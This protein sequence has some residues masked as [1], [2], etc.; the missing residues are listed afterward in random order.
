MLGEYL[1]KFIIAYL[2]NNII[3]LNSEKNIKSIL[4]RFYKDS[5]MK[6]Y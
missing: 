3:Y 5:I 4:N 1:N 2:N 6:R